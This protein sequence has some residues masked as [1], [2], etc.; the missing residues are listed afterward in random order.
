MQEQM[1]FFPRI[2]FP[3]ELLLTGLR[4]TTVLDCQGLF[5]FSSL[6]KPVGFGVH[7]TTTSQL[8]AMWSVGPDDQTSGEEEAESDR[9]IEQEEG[10]ALR[11]AMTPTYRGPGSGSSGEE[12]GR[13]RETLLQWGESVE[14]F[15]STYTRVREHLEKMGVERKQPVAITLSDVYVGTTVYA[16]GHCVVQPFE[17]TRRSTGTSEG[18]VPES[19]HLRL[20][21]KG[22]GT[23]R[24][25]RIVQ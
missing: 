23:R 7:P 2:T 15:E 11:N 6:P 13:G 17:T 19:G 21:T 9:S 10:V 14:R 4:N 5:C 24:G 8:F 22:I 1:A 18:N 3:H 12:G 16:S 20:C 25:D